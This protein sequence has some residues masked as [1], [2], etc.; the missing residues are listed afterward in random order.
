[1]WLVELAPVG[2]AEAV[3]DAI[4]TALGITPQGGARVI[5]TVAEA[6][7]G[8]RVLVVVDNCEH[9]LAAAAGAIGEILA[10]SDVPRVLAT[11]REHLRTPGEALTALCL[12]WPW[13]A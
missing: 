6:V 13:T 1:M 2:D 12:R 7:A 3:P 9:V 11:S 5:D 10:R 8:R 4:A